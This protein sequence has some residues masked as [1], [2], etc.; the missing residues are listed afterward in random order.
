MNIPFSK[1]IAFYPVFARCFGGIN[2]AIYLQQLIYWSDKGKREDGY[3]YKTKRELEE[4]TTLT[5]E[6]QDKCRKYFEGKG[7][8]TTRLLKADG[9]PTLHYKVNLEITENTTETTAETTTSNYYMYL[10]N[11]IPISFCLIESYPP[12]RER[13]NDFALNAGLTPGEAEDAYEY[14]EA[15]GWKRKNGIEIRTWNQVHGL[16]KCWRNNRQR[17]P[18]PEKKETIAEKHARMKREG[19]L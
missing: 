9:A 17:F 1:P 14:Y 4:E 18:K 6:Q 3:I 13:W 7:L 16:L 5:R 19:K 10:Q 11:S 15:N 12:D 8:L 2:N